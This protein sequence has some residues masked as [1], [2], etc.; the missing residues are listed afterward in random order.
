[1][2]GGMF[3]FLIFY[4][5]QIILVWKLTHIRWLTITYGLSLPLSGLFAYWYFHTVNKMRTKWL[6]MLL[7]YKK[8][9]FISNL[10][11]E[12]EQ[13]IAEFDKIKDEYRK[14]RVSK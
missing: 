9:V 4:S 14:M 12:R 2:V 10:I 3:T 7:F 11:T 13:I 5:T 1:M 8:S 6:L